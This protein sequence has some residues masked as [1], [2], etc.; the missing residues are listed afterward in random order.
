MDKATIEMMDKCGCKDCKDNGKCN[1]ID[2]ANCYAS[3]V[4]AVKQ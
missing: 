2:L 3:K 1:M 4:L